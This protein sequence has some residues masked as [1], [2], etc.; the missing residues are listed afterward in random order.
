MPVTDPAAVRLLTHRRVRQVLGA[1]LAGEQTVAGAA[2]RLE[3]DL[4]TVHRDVRALCAAG[5]LRLVREQKRA[6]R[7]VKVYAAVAP[8]FFVPF[9]VTG[10]AALGEL[11]ADH[12]RRHERLFLEAFAR[13]FERLHREQGGGRQWGVRLYLAPEGQV[14]VDQSYEDAALIDAGVR[15]QGPQGLLLNAETAVT[16][17]EAEAREVQAEL[18]RLLMRLRPLTLTHEAQGSGRPYLLRLGLAPVTPQERAALSGAG[19]R[20]PGPAPRAPDAGS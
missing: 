6:G 3:L 17:S 5:L 16:L 19:G 14:Q 7:A 18:I 11:G 1:F 15:Y 4:R 13:E 20:S 12:A 9:S 8:A 10:A 2:R